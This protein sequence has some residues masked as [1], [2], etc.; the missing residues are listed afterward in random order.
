M[1]YRNRQQLV[2]Q[3]V[4]YLFFWGH[5]PGQRG[6]VDASCLSQWY[7]SPFEAN[8]LEYATAEHYM[9]AEKARLF[10]DLATL[11]QI[12]ASSNPGQAKALGRSVQGFVEQTWNECCWD[13]V[14]RGN[15]GKFSQNPPLRDFL[16]AT[17]NRV[18]VEASPHD[19]IWGI[20]LHR[21]DPR[22]AEPAQWLG[23]N[24]LGF[25]LMEV[26]SHLT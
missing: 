2:G 7:E 22:A 9:M 15:L 13:V 19:R 17:Q 21:D 6:Q 23:E 16:L 5:T 18:L 10:G 20:G 12:L 8:G 26:R 24:R 1:P 14:V 4:R 25:A 11:Q 3:P